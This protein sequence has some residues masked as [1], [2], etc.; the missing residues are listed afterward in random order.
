MERSGIRGDRAEA[1][2]SL[3]M[4]SPRI[5][6]RSIRAPPWSGALARLR[7]EAGKGAGQ[8]HAH[9][10]PGLRG[11]GQAEDLLAGDPAAILHITQAQVV[12]AAGRVTL[13]GVDGGKAD[14]DAE[15]GGLEQGFLARPD[16]EPAPA[17]MAGALPGTDLAGAEGVL[18]QPGL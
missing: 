4:A 7:L 6:L 8:A 14:A 2:A 13:F 17:R 12:E 1:G 3:R 5:P 11:P 15:A 9:I 16:T 18:G 10:Q